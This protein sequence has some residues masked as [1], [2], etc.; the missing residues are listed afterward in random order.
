MVNHGD[1]RIDQVFA[2][3]ADPTRRGMVQRLSRGPASIGELGRPYRISKPAVTR[4]VKILE[5]AGLLRRVKA[6]RTHHCRL[7][8]S[9]M[10]A[11]GEWIER[12][13]R[14]WEASIDALAR[15]VESTT[16]DGERT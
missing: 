3:L 1:T 7:D 16:S 8:A 15:Y 12:N 9:G 2:A 10:E 11:A 4:H 6:G 5:R 13:R 14:F